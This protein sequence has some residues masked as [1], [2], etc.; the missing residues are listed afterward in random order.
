[1]DGGVDSEN[2]GKSEGSRVRTDSTSMNP[3]PT[4]THEGMIYRAEI[5]T[6]VYGSRFESPQGDELMAFDRKKL[7]IKISAKST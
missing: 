1:M 6:I 2:R 7:N 3:N 5:N 4:V